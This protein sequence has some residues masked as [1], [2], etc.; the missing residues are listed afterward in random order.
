M[1][2]VVGFLVGFLVL[3]GAIGSAN[4]LNWIWVDGNNVEHAYTLVD[5]NADGITWDDAKAAVVALGTGAYLATI[6]S[7]EEQ[8]AMVA[9]MGGKSSEYWLGG[10]QIQPPAEPEGGWAWDTGESFCYTCWYTNEPNEQGNEDY[11]ATWYQGNWG[12][13]WNDEGALGNIGGYIYETG[14]L[15]DPYDENCNPVPEPTTMLLFGLGILG[16]AGVSRKKS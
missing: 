8:A 11:L 5:V 2:K 13:R 6:T 9:G 7:A 16:L 4:A 3:F 12:G 14:A 1:K 10:Y 15:F